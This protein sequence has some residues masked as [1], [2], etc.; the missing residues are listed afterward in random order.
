MS[1]QK[2]RLRARDET[3]RSRWWR[4][5]MKKRSWQK[6]IRVGQ[7]LLVDT[8]WKI[9][10]NII[11]T[12]GCPQKIII[13][14]IIF[15]A[16]CWMQDENVTLNDQV[17]KNSIIV[18]NLQSQIVRHLLDPVIATL[19]DGHACGSFPHLSGRTYPMTEKMLL[20]QVYD[21]VTGIQKT[22]QDQAVKWFNW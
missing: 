1:A 6:K 10:S 14:I 12:S 17:W 19:C 5:S 2:D 8:S 9:S 3:I 4:G 16:W 20:A 13:I 21:P 18:S 22:K 11:F 7:H 15:P